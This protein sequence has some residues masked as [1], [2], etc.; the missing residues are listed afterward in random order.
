MCRCSHAAGVQS[1]G[2]GLHKN[3]DASPHQGLEEFEWSKP[4]ASTR[5]AFIQGVGAC[6]TLDRT[7][8]ASELF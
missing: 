4:T 5:A 7:V 1:N 8:S 3:I 6:V 2:Y